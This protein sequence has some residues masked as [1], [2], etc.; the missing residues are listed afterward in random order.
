MK[1]SKSNLINKSGLR[2]TGFA[3][4][5]IPYDPE[6]ASSIIT[7]PD[8]V[9]RNMNQADSR[10]QLLDIGPDAW[11]RT[12]W[13]RLFGLGALPR[14]KVGDKVMVPKYAGAVVFGTLD[15]KMYRMLNCDDIYCIIESELSA[16]EI[17]A[18]EQAAKD[19]LAAERAAR[20]SKDFEVELTGRQVEVSNG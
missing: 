20:V 12:W 4:L 19:A 1:S 13:Q 10:V 15:G 3:V 16:Q 6:V 7:I 14:A 2:A 18:K 5:A 11:R 17:A 8:D 9:R